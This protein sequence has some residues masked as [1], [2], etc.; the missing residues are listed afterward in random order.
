MKCSIPS[1]H[2]F[3]KVTAL[4][5]KLIRPRWYLIQSDSELGSRLVLKIIFFTEKRNWKMKLA[6]LGISLDIGTKQILTQQKK[7]LI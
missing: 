4:L 2:K 3:N 1:L 7:K 6:V 5:V